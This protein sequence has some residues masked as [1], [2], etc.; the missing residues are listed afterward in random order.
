MSPLL[1]ILI[2][3]RAAVL[4]LK[5]QPRWLVSFLVLAVLSVVVEML[6]ESH[7]MRAMLDRLPSSATVADKTAVSAM[8]QEATKT[9]LAFFPVR[10]LTG[11][12]TFSLTLFYACRSLFPPGLYRLKHII[13]LEVH[14]EVVLSWRGLQR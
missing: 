5:E 1:R 13:A 6:T 10:L 3:P 14:A 11:W 8:L 7:A 4:D 12:I 2:A 9:R